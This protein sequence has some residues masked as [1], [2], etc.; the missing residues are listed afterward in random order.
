MTNEEFQRS[1]SFEEN[2]KEWNL[3]SLEEMGE[4]VKEGSLYVIGNGFDMLHG[5][6]P[7][8]TISAGLWEREVL[9]GFIWKN[10]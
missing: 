7:A 9:F 2:L 5:V 3:L 1:K 10:I 4:S 6:D 8:I